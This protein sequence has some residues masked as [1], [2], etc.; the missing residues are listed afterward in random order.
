MIRTLQK[1]ICNDIKNIAIKKIHNDKNLA[2]KKICND[3]KNLA[4]KKIYNDKNIAIKKICNDIKN[5]AI[6]KISSIT[7]L[8]ERSPPEPT[9]RLLSSLLHFLQ[10]F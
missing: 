4:I 10:Y 7:G 9:L 8:K 5:I 1:M 3:I 2:I 6:K